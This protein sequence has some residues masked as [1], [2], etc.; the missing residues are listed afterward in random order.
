M[1]IVG[2][3]TDV[4]LCGIYAAAWLLVWLAGSIAAN[5]AYLTGRARGKSKNLLEWLGWNLA[6]IL[7]TINLAAVAGVLLVFLATMPKGY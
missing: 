5:Q 1:L 7:S 2:G 6:M 4:L 3:Y